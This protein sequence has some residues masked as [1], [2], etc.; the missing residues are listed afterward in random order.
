MGYLIGTFQ[1]Q[2]LVAALL[3]PCGFG[4][5]WGRGY[6]VSFCD[7][8]LQC[9]L[10]SH[11]SLVFLWRS[12]FIWRVNLALQ[13]DFPVNIINLSRLFFQ[14]FWK[15]SGHIIGGPSLLMALGQWRGRRNSNQCCWL[16]LKYHSL[17]F[18]QIIFSWLNRNYIEEILAKIPSFKLWYFNF[19]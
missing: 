18:E 12:D 5:Q 7:R 10:P 2:V 14:I 4:Y 9:S 19:Y 8:V 6:L 16:L 15:C 13:V 1:V 11:F 17:I 3:S